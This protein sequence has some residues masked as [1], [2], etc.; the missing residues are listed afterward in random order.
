MKQRLLVMKEQKF[1]P[2]EQAG[3]WATIKVEKAGGVKPG[4]YNIHLSVPADR[5]KS[6]NGLVLHADADH[7][8]QQVTKSVIA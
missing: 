4:I 1:V 8:Y 6:H 3:Q 5:S 7:V 2:T